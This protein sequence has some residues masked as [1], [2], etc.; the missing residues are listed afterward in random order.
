MPEKEPL[1]S[2]TPLDR[3][4]EA[5]GMIGVVGCLEIDENGT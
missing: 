2:L 1:Q 3:I 4:L 5:K